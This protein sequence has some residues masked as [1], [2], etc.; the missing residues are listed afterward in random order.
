MIQNL[1]LLS[2]KAFKNNFYLQKFLYSFSQESDPL[3]K[4][5]L[6]LPS[7]QKRIAFDAIDGGKR[8]SERESTYR[9]GA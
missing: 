3:K 5:I 8:L 6:T 2:T 7:L 1:I 4:V 9:I